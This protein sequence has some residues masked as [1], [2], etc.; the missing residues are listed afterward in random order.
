VKVGREAPNEAKAK[1]W[2]VVVATTTHG[3]WHALGP[4]RTHTNTLHQPLSR[5][6]NHAIINESPTRDNPP[7]VFFGRVGT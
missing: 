1:F 7:L 4:T 2:R 6:S 5:A 3:I